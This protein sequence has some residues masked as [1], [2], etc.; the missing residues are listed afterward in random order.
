MTESKVILE[1]KKKIDC[2]TM[3]RG[4]NLKILKH[5]LNPNLDNSQGMEEGVGD[6]S[7]RL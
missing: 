7:F 4:E 6:Y 2:L 1:G 3:R 5:V